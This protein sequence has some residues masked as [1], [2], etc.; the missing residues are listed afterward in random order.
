MLD[1]LLDEVAPA[2][3]ALRPAPP[4]F[5]S[6]RAGKAMPRNIPSTL[7][8]KHLPQERL[9]T[10]RREGASLFSTLGNHDRPGSARPAVPAASARPRSAGSSAAR[11]C[12]ARRAPVEHDVVGAFAASSQVLLPMHL[13]KARPVTERNASIEAVWAPPRRG[14]HDARPASRN[15]LSNGMRRSENA[16]A[17]VT[18]K[19]LD[20]YCAAEAAAARTQLLLQPGLRPPLA[21]STQPPAG[22]ANE[23]ATRHATRLRSIPTPEG[24]QKSWRPQRVG[25][26]NAPMVHYRDPQDPD[27]FDKAARVFC[28]SLRPDAPPQKGREPWRAWASPSAHGVQ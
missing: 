16:S 28:T 10:P 27:V 8:A 17:F 14:R 23:D 15:P 2:R 20:S 1:C 21:P 7:W 3:P 6:D 4:A 9:G 13:R 25:P 19:Q 12:S 5:D 11:P 22:L 18:T 24:F 26:G